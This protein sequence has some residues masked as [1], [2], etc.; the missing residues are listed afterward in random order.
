M[1]LMA[2]ATTQVPEMGAMGFSGETWVEQS[3]ARV[4]G[5]VESVAPNRIVARLSQ[6]TPQT[7]ALNSG[8]PVPFPRLN[9]F[10]IVPHES[11]A[12]V[13]IVTWIGVSQAGM[14]ARAARAE[15]DLIDL[16]FPARRM[17]I[18][19]IGTLEREH[20]RETSA[21][22][23]QRG[24]TVFPSVGDAIS[25]PSGDQ[26]RALMAG[27]AAHQHVKIGS[28]L[29]ANNSDVT[30]D[31]NKLFGRHLAVL[32]N[33]GSGK[34]CSVAGLIRWSLEAAFAT[35]K[36]ENHEGP[37][38]S[39][40]IVLDPNGEYGKA[41]DGIAGVRH[42]RVDGGG[43]AEPLQVPGW[44]MNS[45]EWASVSYASA[46][47]Q[48]PVLIKAL[49]E[50]RSSLQDDAEDL[51]QLVAHVGVVARRYASVITAKGRPDAPDDW[52]AIKD[53]LRSLTRLIDELSFCLNHAAFNGLEQ[54]T[55]QLLRSAKGNADAAHRHG[56]ADPRNPIMP[57]RVQFVSMIE[58]L[59]E[60]ADSVPLPPVV[61]LA[62]EDTPSS[63]RL[64]ELGSRLDAVVSSGQFDDAKKHVGGLRLRI[65][66]LLA[67]ERMSPVLLTHQKEQPALDDWLSQFLGDG[68]GDSIAV[69]DLSL[70]PTDVVEVVTAVAARMT[71]EALQ[72]Q[73]RHD[74]HGRVV[75]TVLVLE[76]AHTFVRGRAFNDEYTTP[77]AL[78]TQAFERI[79]REGRKF[80]LGLVISS[81]RPSELS[82]TVLAQC[83]SFLLHRIVNHRDQELVGK[84][85]P[86][87][88][89]GMLDELPALP[90]RH[91][92]LLG[93]AAPFPTL[94][95]MRELEKDHRP[96]S[97]DPDYWGS[98][99][100]AN[101]VSPDWKAV[102][103]D[104]AGQVKPTDQPSDAAEAENIAGTTSSDDLTASGEPEGSP[105]RQTTDPFG[106]APPLADDDIPF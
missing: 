101:P 36:E 94:V 95:Q 100:G 51:E 17:M 26:L 39:R 2:T 9:G 63:F 103:E 105:Q 30:V 66:A 47:M 49:R 60:L 106:A 57:T 11:G 74:E 69:I 56:N 82:E 68:S 53:M 76:E 90:S 67:D 24:V 50:L 7:T 20:E 70:V 29:L 55:Q 18:T 45:H 80:G 102:A 104:W 96:H 71:F 37:A 62:H 16:P 42:Y 99:T 65:D 1:V 83:N 3:K 78:C 79:A 87:N 84:L 33:T 61:P 10:V 88:L 85:V 41:F 21:Y 98:W 91:A 13:G 22:R 64:T 46:R 38:S 35:R 15:P 32:G 40:F 31:P 92:L 75:P 97:E 89:T 12:L 52:S 19:P 77:G 43:G 25:V 34:S 48:K 73:R 14:P 6:E 4:I 23:L 28:A 27:D 81:Q 8:M 72:R 5:S 44:L 86:D 58:V 59:S 93:W 54:G